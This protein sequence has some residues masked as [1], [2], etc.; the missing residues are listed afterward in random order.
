MERRTLQARPDGPP[1][2]PDLL[3]VLAE[4]GELALVKATPDQ[5]RRSRK[6]RR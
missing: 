5:P 1:A 4:E 6:F 3:L 2:D